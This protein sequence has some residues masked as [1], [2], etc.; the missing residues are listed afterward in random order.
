MNDEKDTGLLKEPA[1]TLE[2]IKIFNVTKRHMKT[3]SVPVTASLHCHQT[4]LPNLPVEPPPSLFAIV[5]NRW[6]VVSV[7]LPGWKDQTRN[8]NEQK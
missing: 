3:G 8:F 7:K 2:M 5:S 6:N 1:V 4:N